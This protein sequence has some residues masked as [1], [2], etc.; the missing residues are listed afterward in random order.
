[1]HYRIFVFI[2]AELRAVRRYVVDAE[3]ARRC[4]LSPEIIAAVAKYFSELSSSR[5]ASTLFFHIC[6]SSN[7]QMIADALA[8]LIGSWV[9]C[10]CADSWLAGIVASNID[11]MGI[12]SQQS[13]C[14]YMLH[15]WN[16]RGTT[17]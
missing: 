12:S 1:V 16:S 14:T 10:K 15:L 8:S 2:C 7:Y 3:L 4:K 11:Q 17:K 13:I 6:I 5:E 9:K